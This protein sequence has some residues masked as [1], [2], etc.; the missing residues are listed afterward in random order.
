M[1]FFFVGGLEQQ[2]RQVVKS[3]VGRCINCGSRADM[4]EYD[5]VLKL[6]F[7]PVWRWPGKEPLLYCDN[8]KFLFPRSYSL[9]P[10]AD[11]GTPLPPAVSDALRCRFCDRVVESDFRF[12]PFCGSEL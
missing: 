8:C 1:F 5:K 4:V 7:V 3:G 11:A 9:P 6:F 2:V 12:C 10:N